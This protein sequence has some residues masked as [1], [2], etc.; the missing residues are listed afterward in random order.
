MPLFF[1]L[2]L[3]KVSLSG[4]LMANAVPA[5]DF[6]CKLLIHGHYFDST[7]TNFRVRSAT[8]PYL[9]YD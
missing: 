5:P 7:T 4:L 9:L 8:I 2:T 3:D 6:S 1:S